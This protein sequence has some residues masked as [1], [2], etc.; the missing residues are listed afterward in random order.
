MTGEIYC[1]TGGR[2]F[3]T[4][5]SALSSL[6]F[7]LAAGAAS[8]QSF[9]CGAAKTRVEKAICHD[10]KLGAQDAALNALYGAT[11]DVAA[12]PDALVADQRAWMKARDK[13][14]DTACLSALY[15]TRI[16][17]LGRVTKAGWRTYS[18][19]KL[20]IRFDMLTNRTVGA[21]RNEPGPDCIALFGRDGGRKKELIEIKVGTGDL[22]KAVTDSAIFDLQDGKW[23]AVA[24]PGM[25]AEADHFQGAGWTGIHATISCG[26]SDKATGFHAAG[27]DCFWAV[28]SNGK[29]SATVGSDGTSSNDAN[30]FKTVTSI[31]FEP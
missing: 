5:L 23:M 26:I 17:A 20:H 28:L 24:G 8:A 13:C 4:W 31:R 15:T 1:R 25:P 22:A 2:P 12:A 9:D 3:K 27:G 21:C 18:D 14:A 10:K 7:V 16:A 19:A 29:R 30:T 6:A 11:V